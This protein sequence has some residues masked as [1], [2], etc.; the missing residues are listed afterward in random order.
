MYYLFILSFFVC[1]HFRKTPKGW[2]LGRTRPRDK[3]CIITQ[4]IRPSAWSGRGAVRWC[5]CKHDC[6][7]W[8]TLSCPHSS[9]SFSLADIP[10]AYHH[11]NACH[12][13][14]HHGD[15]FAGHSQSLPWPPSLR[16]VSCPVSRLA[17]VSSRRAATG[18][19][20]SIQPGQRPLTVV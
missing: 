7:C 14:L 17:S 11:P 20:P 19:C 4:A 15:G 9:A 3:T 1:I 13:C 10:S 2:G 5:V 12:R 18:I 8:N 16:V 6:L